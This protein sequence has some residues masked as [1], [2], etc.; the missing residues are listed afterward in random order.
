MQLTWMDAKVGDWVVT[1]R[2][3]KPVE[4]NALWYNALLSMADF[5]RRLER[6][7]DVY[8]QLAEA[9]RLGFRRF[10]LEGDGGLCDVL[11]GPQ[12]KDA[13][14]RPNQILAVSLTHSPLAAEAQAVVVS[15]VAGQLLSSFGL[16]SLAP[17]HPDY[18]SRYG[19]GVLERDGAYHQGPVWAWLLGH[20]ALAEFRVSGDAAAAQRRLDAIADHLGDAGLGTVSE[21]FDGEAPHT[22]RG[23]PAQAWSVACILEA[24][25]RLQAARDPAGP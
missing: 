5:A 9:A 19:G 10:V 2:S 14:L 17:A 3:G 12:G 11:D 24:W 15:C 16:R 1:P 8:E 21:I 4:I 18:R 25:C 7:A 13:S 23:A 20:Y 6:P 22:P